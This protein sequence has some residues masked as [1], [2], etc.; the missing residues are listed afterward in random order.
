MMYDVKKASKSWN[1]LDSGPCFVL[2][3]NKNLQI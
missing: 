3:L 2:L 1:L